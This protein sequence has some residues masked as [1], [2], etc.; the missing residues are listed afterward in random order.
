M[1]V[2]SCNYHF[3]YI[4]NDFC[5]EIFHKIFNFFHSTSPPRDTFDVWWVRK[6][7]LAEAFVEQRRK[8]K[9]YFCVGKKKKKR[10]KKF[11]FME[12]GCWCGRRERKFFLFK[13]KN[14]RGTTTITIFQVSY[15][16]IKCVPRCQDFRITTNV[17]EDVFPTARELK[18]FVRENYVG[19]G[20]ADAHY[21]ETFS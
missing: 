1:E 6:V 15:V 12:E 3:Q 9:I 8:K 19:V 17:W 7:R 2:I 5:R 18:D 4:Q 21:D 20:T 14:E 10:R 13:P 11:I 16:W